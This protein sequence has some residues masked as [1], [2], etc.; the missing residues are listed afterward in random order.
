MT[1]DRNPARKG[2]RTPP[3]WTISF[4]ANFLSAEAWSPSSSLRQALKRR[5]RKID[6]SFENAFLFN[7]R[8]TAPYRGGLLLLRLSA[9]LLFSPDPPCLLLFSG[10]F[11]LFLLFQ[12]KNSMTRE[13]LPP[14][15]RA[16]QSSQ[17]TFACWTQ[18]ERSWE[19]CVPMKMTSSD[20]V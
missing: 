18:G 6:R 13:S 5:R 10:A 14:S 7:S 17:F 4:I 11:L 15:S 12:F 2:R 9:S 8:S 16:M 20:E 19:R 3:V 1:W